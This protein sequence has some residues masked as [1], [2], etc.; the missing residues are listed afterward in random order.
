MAAATYS[1]ALAWYSSIREWL[2]DHRTE[3]YTHSTIKCFKSYR[4]FLK[5]C[6]KS[7]RDGGRVMAPA[8]VQ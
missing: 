3:E 8:A 2:S 5:K 1:I 6:Q 7:G 4:Q